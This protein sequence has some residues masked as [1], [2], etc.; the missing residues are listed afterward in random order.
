[1]RYLKL[2]STYRGAGQGSHKTVIEQILLGENVSTWN[3]IVW[4]KDNLKNLQML[5]KDLAGDALYPM[6]LY[7]P[8]INTV[9]PTL[10]LYEY[11]PHNFEGF[12]LVGDRAFC[13]IERRSPDSWLGSFIFVGGDLT[14]EEKKHFADFRVREDAKRDKT[15]YQNI[16]LLV[17]YGGGDLDFHDNKVHLS[18]FKKENYTDENVNWLPRLKEALF[19][20]KNTGRLTICQGPPGT[21]KTRYLRALMQELGESVCPVVLPVA[22]S[23]ELSSPR[24]LGVITSNSDFSKKKILLIIEDGDQLLEKRE[25]SS[26]VISDFLN[27]I[28]GLIGEV[29]DLHVVVT[30]NL[31]KKDF[32]PAITRPGRLHSI[33]YFDTLDKAQAS[34]VYKRETGE[35]LTGDVEKYTLA[36]IYAKVNDHHNGV[37][38]KKKLAAGAYL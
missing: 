36:E 28:D 35:E 27:V 1:M 12:Y 18:E 13:W 17:D 3:G 7:S 24:M 34:K 16:W 4:C 8:H 33:L 2:A 21:G 9:E 29:V 32:D 37:R 20:P 26:S 25:R 23:H 14:D 6:A 31:Q 15:I 11:Q 19:N 10:D 5:L 22:L 38:E 30:T